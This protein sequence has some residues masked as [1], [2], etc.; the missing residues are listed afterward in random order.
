[1]GHEV[2]IIFS[3]NWSLDSKQQKGRSI[4]IIYL[5][6]FYRIKPRTVHIVYLV[7]KKIMPHIFLPTSL[8]TKN[9]KLNVF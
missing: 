8:Q 6:L 3:L 9:F 1:M 4:P 5:F 7:L 2:S